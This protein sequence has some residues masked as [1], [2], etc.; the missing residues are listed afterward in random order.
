MACP[1][2][3]YCEA[4]AG[5]LPCPKGH[6]CLESTKG[7]GQYPCEAGFYNSVKKAKDV[8]QCL[9][10]G[11]GNFCLK[12][13]IAPQPC[14]IGTFNNFSNIASECKA[15]PEGYKCESPG[16]IHP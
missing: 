16:T 12:A 8:M 14:A 4:G 3:F 11:V 5:P 7:R 6:Y 1:I 15:C 2:G 10:C 9:R 13:S